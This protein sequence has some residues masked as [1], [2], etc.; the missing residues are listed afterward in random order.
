MSVENSTEDVYADIRL[1][2]NH[3]KITDA[4]TRL[5]S[6]KNYRILAISSVPDVDSVKF[7]IRRFTEIYFH[8]NAITSRKAHQLMIEYGLYSLILEFRDII[9]IRDIITEITLCTGGGLRNTEFDVEKIL[10]PLGFTY[11]SQNLHVFST[12]EQSD[13]IKELQS[14]LGL[15]SEGIVGLMCIIWSMSATFKNMNVSFEKSGDLEKLNMCKQWWVG[16]VGKEDETGLKAQI[17]KYAEQYK[18]DKLVILKEYLEYLKDELRMF[19]EGK[20]TTIDK[21]GFDCVE[22][23]IERIENSGLDIGGD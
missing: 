4:Y 11:V 15:R 16:D 18:N 14:N 20:R 12:F 1:L 22:K 23:I 7:L 17:I 9:Q 8:K 10:Y 21:K 5:K 13:K 6:D 19:N 3:L 2:H